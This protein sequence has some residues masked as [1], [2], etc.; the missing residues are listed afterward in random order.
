M[1]KYLSAFFRGQQRRSAL[2]HLQG[3]DDRML[4]DIGIT[5]DDLSTMVTRAKSRNVN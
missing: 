3:M 4:R 2:R 5:R 1:N